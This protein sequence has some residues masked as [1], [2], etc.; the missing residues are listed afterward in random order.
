[1]QV[2]IVPTTKTVSFDSTT[3]M[4]HSFSILSSTKTIS[5]TLFHSFIA[6]FF[7]HYIFSVYVLVYN[8]IMVNKRN[9]RV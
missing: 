8:T 2:S 3:Q 5:N 9:A 1:M 4:Q 6:A 7:L